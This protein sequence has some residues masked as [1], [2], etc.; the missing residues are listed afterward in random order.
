MS[1]PAPAIV[2]L[3]GGT[4]GWMAACLFRHRWPRAAVTLVE[5]PEIG[6]VGVGEGS[7]PQLRGLLRTLGIPEARWMPAAD[8]TY[9][10]GIR[11]DGW[12][13]RPG[14]GSYFHPFASA[15]DL[16]TQPLFHRAALARR[17]GHAVDAH[18]DG[19]FLNS[20]LAA[21]GLAPVAGDG[22]P[23]E[24]GYG[25]H[26]DAARIGHVLRAH[27]TQAG[28]V[29]R[30]GR[31]GAVVRRED[32]GIAALRT[33]A[34]E[35]AGDLFVDASG[36]EGVLARA[37]GTRFLPFAGNLFNDRAVVIPTPRGGGPLDAHTTATA[38][39]AGWAWRIPLTS[40]TG[41]GY[42]YAS[43]Y[44]DPEAAEREL[45]AHLGVGDEGTAR[46]LAMRVGRVE[47]SW[48]ANC[49]AIGLAQGFIEPL[50]ATALHLVQATVEG[51]IESFSA[52]G[53]DPAARQAFNAAIA[54]RYEGVRDYIVCHYRLNGRTDTAYWR[55][56]AANDQ[57]SDDLKAIMTRWFTGGDVAAEVAH[58]DLL[59]YYTPLSWE[60][61]LAGYGTFPEEARLR[62]SPL[63]ASLAP[64][65]TFLDRCSLNFP[66]HAALLDGLHERTAA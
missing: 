16:H 43:R 54:R 33:D 41:N 63:A 64:P 23:F 53:P 25:Y 55:D 24:V 7:T 15:I 31:V 35:I 13:A 40:R 3:G 59:D 60:C 6:I 28:A 57:I 20:R 66:P 61:L 56:N 12:S 30:Q 46:H 14:G 36:F 51:F 4:A 37:L 38:L 49:L 42:V 45:R 1:G 17:T 19:F 58:R 32:G 52:H 50:E 47:A 22:F 34:G 8:A 65:R 48:T 44:L 29:H 10:L 62:P 2:I 39:S 26:L 18:P 9:K 27:A 21:A 5:A 11:F